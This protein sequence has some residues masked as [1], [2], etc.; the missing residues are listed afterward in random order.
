MLLLV[1][2]GTRSGKSEVAERAAARLGEPVTV[3]VPAVVRDPEFAARVAAHRERRPAS[4][5]TLEC[6]DDVVPAVAAAR[7]TVLLDSLG[8]WVAGADEFAV[9]GDAL[10]DALRRRDGSTVVV[11]E[12]VGLSVHA[13]TDVGRHFADALGA[14]NAKVAAAADRVV[15][16]VAGRAVELA[17]AD[18]VVGGG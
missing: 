6:G 14:V 17:P 2:G 4:W 13:P 5:T 7:G 8:T 1:V 11:A 18:D 12:E 15:L 16:V 10:V 3:V 9:D